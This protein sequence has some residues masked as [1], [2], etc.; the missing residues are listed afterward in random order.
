MCELPLSFVEKTSGLFV[1][2]PYPARTVFDHAHVV[3]AVF[4]FQSNYFTTTLTFYF[5]F[6]FH[7]NA[8]KQ[9]LAVIFTSIF[10]V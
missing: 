1:T 10:F 8:F 6:A 5:Y 3:T 7:K 9:E 2:H 4:S